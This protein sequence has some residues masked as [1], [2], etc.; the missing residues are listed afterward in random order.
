MNDSRPARAGTTPI[1]IGRG[2]DRHEQYI[3]DGADGGVEAPSRMYYVCT[4]WKNI[5]IGDRILPS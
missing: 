5:I 2:I 1:W 4:V 3:R